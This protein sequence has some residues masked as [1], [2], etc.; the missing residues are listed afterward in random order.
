MHELGFLSSLVIYCPRMLTGTVW[1]PSAGKTDVQGS[2]RFLE[3]P[4]LLSGFSA[5]PPP[6]G[7][8]GTEPGVTEVPSP[9]KPM[10][11][12]GRWKPSPGTWGR[13]WAARWGSRGCGHPHVN[14]SRDVRA[15]MH[16][17]AQKGWI[18]LENTPD[19]N[20]SCQ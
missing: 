2:G 1:S 11:V 4:R 20:T 7:S 5:A 14:R 15:Q 6:L 12:A 3:V 13:C 9:H 8:A 19:K 17:E 18:T 16:W 10:G